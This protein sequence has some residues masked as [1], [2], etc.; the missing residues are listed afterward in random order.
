VTGRLPSRA[1]IGR[2]RAPFVLATVLAFALVPLTTPTRFGVYA[3]AAVLAVLVGVLHIVLGATAR[4]VPPLVFLLAASLLRE[5]GGG[6]SSGVGSLALLPV[7]W[8]AL[9]GTRRQLAVVLAAV[10]AYYLVPIFV[11]GGEA[12]PASGYR[13]AVMFVVISGI[14]GFTVQRLVAQ[15]RAHADETARRHSDLSRAAALVAA[16]R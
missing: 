1:Q 7:F 14:V 6:T 4:V 3:A 10:G 13:T 15:V 5:A 2:A 16:S 12:Y 9:H 8:V 11:V